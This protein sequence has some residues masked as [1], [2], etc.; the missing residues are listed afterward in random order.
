MDEELIREYLRRFDQA[1][2]LLE[3]KGEPSVWF[4][5]LTEEF[6]RKNQ[7]VFADR[8]LQGE[9]DPSVYASSALIFYGYRLG[10]VK[11]KGKNECYTRQ[12]GYRDNAI[13]QYGLDEILDEETE[14]DNP[15]ARASH[16]IKW[17]TN[18][19]SNTDISDAVIS[20]MIVPLVNNLCKTTPPGKKA[21]CT[22]IMPP[23]SRD[24]TIQDWS[25]LFT[26]VKVQDFKINIVHYGQLLQLNN[27]ER[28]YIFQYQTD[29]YR[30]YVIVAAY[31]VIRGH[32][33]C[34]GCMAFD[35]DD[36]DRQYKLQDVKPISLNINNSS[37]R[38]ERTLREEI[39]V[40]WEYRDCKYPLSIGFNSFLGN[41]AASFGREMYKLSGITDDAH[42]DTSS[43]KSV[44]HGNEALQAFE[45][46]ARLLQEHN[47]Y[48]I[49]LGDLAYVVN[50]LERDKGFIKV[51][52]RT[53]NKIYQL[54]T[55]KEFAASVNIKKLYGLPSN[56]ASISWQ[57]RDKRKELMPYF[58]LDAKKHS[59]KQ[60][61]ESIVDHFEHCSTADVAEELLLLYKDGEDPTAFFTAK[62]FMYL[63]QMESLVIESRNES[64]SVIEN[65]DDIEYQEIDKSQIKVSHPSGGMTPMR[66]KTIDEQQKKKAVVSSLPIEKMEFSVRT[67]NCLHRAKINTVGEITKKTR[68]DLMKIRNLG[69]TSQEEVI[70]K[71]KQ[72]G[73]KLAD[74]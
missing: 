30:E 14:D 44:F 7:Q 34:L 4:I 17:I 45:V 24:I 68:T 48:N 61:I 5:E 58:Y 31:E 73:L 67:Y 43:I 57:V 20:K 8:M 71:L 11:L 72:L 6:L 16:I 2:A 21:E 49:G 33:T 69:Y 37:A 18:P 22:V 46:C 55:F 26:D 29:G 23:I 54:G 41:H 40:D 27:D 32:N 70:A 62:V 51:S 66:R 36:S 64:V 59:E 3:R 12:G 65:V 53:G 42:F 9:N 50:I 47:L 35:V 10:A 1:F 15:D 74:E 60:I 13:L 38:Y 25:N 56:Y 28:G 52:V 19:G 39:T 63:S